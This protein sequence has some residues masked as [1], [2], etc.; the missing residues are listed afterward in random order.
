MPDFLRKAA[1]ATFSLAVTLA[2]VEGVLRV[3]HLGPKQFGSG[4]QYVFYRFDPVLG[5]SNL[6][7][8][9]GD[10]ARAEFQHRVD[11][12][13]LAM[14]DREPGPRAAGN[15]AVAVLGDSF[16]WGLGAAYGERYTEVMEQ[17]D[18]RIDAWNYGVSGYAPVQYLLE[19]DEVLKRKPDF[20][21]LAFCLSNDLVDNVTSVASGYE[22]P[23]ARTSNDG[24]RVEVTGY[25]LHELKSIGTRLQGE[26]SGFVIVALLQRWWAELLQPKETLSI[27]T[28]FQPDSELGAQERAARDN[29]WKVNRLLLADIRDK[30]Q[31]ALGPG[32]FAILLVP[33]QESYGMEGSKAPRGSNPATVAE[34]VLAQLKEL[35]IPAIDAREVIR[36][37]DFWQ[38]DGHW[39]PSGHAKVG[40]MVAAWLAKAVPAAATRP[41]STPQP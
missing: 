25:P 11:T 16:T 12:N 2:L 24:A 38:Q 41:A 35:S 14:R 10:F 39:R 6:P 34:G 4:N 7:S 37:E 9:S 29:A 32:R 1:L 8:A 17:A 36:P 18:P 31:A 33:G 30:V 21:L 19:L 3:F 28:F 23:W 5:W 27:A 20:V 13:S 26:S 22:K 40:R 15:L